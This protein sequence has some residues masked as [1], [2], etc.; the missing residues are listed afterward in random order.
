M[1]RAFFSMVQAASCKK[2]VK[3]PASWIDFYF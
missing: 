3:N 2:A 1:R